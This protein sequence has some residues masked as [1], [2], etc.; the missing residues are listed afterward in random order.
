MSH[1]MLRPFI[2]KVLVL[3]YFPLYTFNYIFKYIPYNVEY[4]YLNYVT[5]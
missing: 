1:K 4:I 3:G 5:Y 2:D